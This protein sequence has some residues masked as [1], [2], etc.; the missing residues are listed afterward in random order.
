M[1]QKFDVTGMTCSACSAH[2]DKSVRKLDGVAEVN[3]NLLQNTM[4]VE[5][6]ESEVNDDQIIR[7]VIGGGYGAFV[8][9]KQE[10]AGRKRDIGVDDEITGMKRRLWVSILFM[11]HFHGAYGESSAPVFSERNPQRGFLRADPDAPG[12]PGHVY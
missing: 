12:S 9:D 10:E 6:D 5:Y 11:I 1:K 8:H 2:V 4:T 7:A 3:V